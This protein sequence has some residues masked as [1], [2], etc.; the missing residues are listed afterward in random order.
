MSSSRPNAKNK[1]PA[2]GKGW[3]VG[4]RVWFERAG[5]GLLGPGRLELLEG[6]DRHHSI[7]AAARQMGMSFRRAWTQVQ[8]IN[9]AAGEPLVLAAPGGRH[10]GGAELTPLG[11]WAV[12]V[13]REMQ[14][15]L[16]QTAASL[17]PRLVQPAAAPGLHVAAAV[18]LEEVLGQLLTDF[19]LREPTL[20]VRAVF[21]A[22]D[23][24]A[25]HLLAG[26]PADLFLTADPHQLDALAVA[27]LV[28][29]EQTAPLA[30]NGLAAIALAHHELPVRRPAALAR[31]DAPRLALAEP[32]CPLGGYTRAYLERLHLY[33]RLRQRAVRA[34]SSRAV[35]AAVR[36]GQAD[37]GLVYAS[38]AARAEGFRILFRVRQSPVPI[39]YTAAILSRTHDAGAAARLLDFLTSAVA[40]RRFRQCGFQP[41][42]R[43]ALA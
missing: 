39:R 5:Q 4:L 16:H 43:P 35:L 3:S 41:I 10:G 9:E 13:F 30:T 15:T 32:D 11:A 37:V 28:R 24:L 38:D 6:I 25:V 19:T 40:A 2:W 22:S 7:S 34:E 1:A 12:A 27:G 14:D 17:L 31:A 18:S 33:E 20:R 26:A 42:S 23:E 8:R 21:G 29:P 36:S